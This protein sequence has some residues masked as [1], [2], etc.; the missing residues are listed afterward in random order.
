[1]FTKR[2]VEIS[3][4]TYLI[5]YSRPRFLRLHL[6]NLNLCFK[7]IL[8]ELI[9]YN[10]EVKF[11]HKSFLQLSKFIESHF[12]TGETLNSH[13]YPLYI[14]HILRRN[15]SL[16]GIKDSKAGY[17][18]QAKRIISVIKIFG[19]CINA[20]LNVHRICH[21]SDLK[22]CFSNFIQKNPLFLTFFLNVATTVSGSTQLNPSNDKEK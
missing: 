4:S 12:Q 8:L 10:S 19:E 13:S 5:V 20:D 18:K 2:K 21:S 22:Q 11:V 3:K 16:D 14:Y 17:T 9:I 6:E 1:V 15:D 7:C